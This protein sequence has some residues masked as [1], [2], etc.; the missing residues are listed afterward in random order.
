MLENKSNEVAHDDDSRDDEDAD[1]HRDDE[2][3]TVI[4]VAP[5]PV[6]ENA[7]EEDFGNYNIM[8]KT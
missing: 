2:D 6:S 4:H 3:G 7:D 5:E 8:K 1:N